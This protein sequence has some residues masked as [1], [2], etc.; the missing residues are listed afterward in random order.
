MV[1]AV[2][3]GRFYRSPFDMNVASFSLEPFLAVSD[4]IDWQHPAIV[5]QAQTLASGCDG[6]KAIAR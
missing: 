6:K 5:T 1:S 4:V 2:V 3:Q